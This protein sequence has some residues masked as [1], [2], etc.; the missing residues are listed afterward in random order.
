MSLEQFDNVDWN[1][2]TPNIWRRCVRILL[3]D[4][5]VC[6]SLLIAGELGLRYFV[7][8]SKSFVYSKTE[9][10]GNPI[11]L[12]SRGLREREFSTSPL[13][14]ERRVLCIGDSTTFGT[15]VAADETFAKQLQSLL[16][17]ATDRQQIHNYVI[18]AGGQGKS[19]EETTVFL[20]SKGLSYEP[21][22][23][24]LGFSPHMIAKTYLAALAKQDADSDSEHTETLSLRT[25]ARFAIHKVHSV[26]YSTRIYACADMQFRK[27]LYRIGVLRDMI[28]RP[29]GA[30]FA[31]AFDEPLVDQSRIESSYEQFAEQLARLK[32]LL[33]ERNT[34]L[35]VISIPSRF[36]ISQNSVDNIR[37]LPLNR[38]RIEPTK[39][40]GQ[41][42]RD[43]NIAH[44]DLLPSF[45][46][47][48]QRMLNNQADWNDLYV[49]HDYTHL[50]RE[51]HA[52]VA[53][54]LQKTLDQNQLIAG[55]TDRGNTIV[56]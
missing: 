37:N 22:L 4:L 17:Q 39:R 55:W 12:N 45:R 28:E 27:R 36:E 24:V 31:Y 20:R 14:S 46:T 8:S 5:L 18:N 10:A 56:R 16:E 38:I 33:D 11:E 41:I 44:L 25:R 15:G 9:T 21:S 23:V 35:L 2:A 30:P 40:L 3:I 32:A 48:R 26:L 1:K 53:S 7:P 19:L 13:A 49:L 6:V 54:Q 51:G 52:I 34:P 29:K 42:C 47:E 50:N 43:L